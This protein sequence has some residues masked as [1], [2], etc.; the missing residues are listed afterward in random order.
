MLKK[1]LMVVAISTVA[2]SAFAAFPA[3]QVEK[4]ILLK[5]GSTVYILKDGKMAMEDKNG[6]AV[7]MKQGEVMETKDGKKIMMHGDEVMRLN[8]ILHPTSD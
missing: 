6:R 7:R 5:N 8:S 2:A 3:E 1:L 4:S